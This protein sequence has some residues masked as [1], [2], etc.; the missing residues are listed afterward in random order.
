MAVNLSPIG[1]VA[2]QFLDNSGNPLSG[3][4]IYTYAAGTTTPQSTYT[5]SNGA[6]AHA[7]PIILDAAGRVPT[8][9]IWLT[10]GL[11]Y[12][13]IIKTSTDVQI[14]SYDNIIGINSNFVNYT[15]SQEIQTATSGQTVFTLTTMVYQPGTNSLSVFVDGVNQY[16][17]GASYAFQET[18]DTVV[19]FTTGLHVGAVVKF[20]TSAIN[21]SSYG[22]AEQISYTPPFASSVA[23]NVEAKLAQT[24]SVKDFGAVGDGVTDDTAAIQAALNYCETNGAFLS[25]QPGTYLITS[26]LTIKCNGD[27]SLMEIE[28]DATDFSPAIQVG[29]ATAGQYLFDVELVL[30]KITNTAKVGTGW[31]GFDTAIGVLC[32]NV[33]Q[34]RITAPYIY[35]F[36]VGLKTGGYGVGNVYNTYYIGVLFGNKINLQCMP[37]DINGW[38]N[39]NTFIGG[40]YGYSSAEGSAVSGVIQI[41][42]RDFSAGG[43]NAPN[44]NVWLNPSVEGNEPEFHFDIQGSY[45]TI[46]SPRLE[47]SGGVSARINFHAVSVNE[48]VANNFIAGYKAGIT[49]SFSGAGTSSSNGYLAGRGGNTM[50]FSGSG[51]NVRNG[52]GNTLT[53]P[54]FQGF[55]AAVQPLPKDETSTDWTYRIYGEG[56]AVKATGNTQPKVQI[57]ASGYVFFGSGTAAV[58]GGLR[59]NATP[60]AITSNIDFAPDA[61]AT[62]KLGTANR[63]WAQI[64]ATLPTYADNAAALAGGLTAGAF[65]KTAAGD[66]RVVV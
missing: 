63:Q 30:P 6:T 9:E 59:Y 22:D 65:Y 61:D 37:G 25:G 28:A 36:G 40:R 12:K 27:L 26:T 8:G 47:L 35:N 55:P 14:G 44:T 52:S 56:F 51:Y 3:G 49:Y 62:L 17:P 57:D 46:I 4:K 45:N 5:S 10:D 43:A 13:F 41:Q 32:A 53:A 20:T 48:T 31:T 64:W 21:A 7:N 16:G 66:V 24:V 19:T 58:A 33:Y 11:Q 18:S 34:S 38:S 39:Q 54:H 2:A 15:N 1:G 60:A 50:D 23:T 29:P 42:L